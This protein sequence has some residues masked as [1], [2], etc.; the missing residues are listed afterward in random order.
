MRDIRD[1]NSCYFVEWIPHNIKIN[2]CDV[3]PKGIKMAAA[4]LGNNTSIQQMFKRVG[5]AYTGMFRKKAFMHWYT[6][7]GMDEHEFSASESNVNDLISEYQQ[8]E[9]MTADDPLDAD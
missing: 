4:F 2:L 9:D 8:Y 5:E 7:E 3:P 1:K 6:G